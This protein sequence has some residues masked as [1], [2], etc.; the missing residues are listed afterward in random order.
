MKPD[1]LLD[2]ASG[3]LW[4]WPEIFVHHD[5]DKIDEAITWHQDTITMFGRRSPLPRLTAWY[6]DPAAVYSYSGI[7][8]EPLP[9]SPLL[10]QLKED[11]ETCTGGTFNAVLANR[12]VEGTQYM[13]WHADDEAAL[14]KEPWV[15]SVSLGATRRFL[16]KNRRDQRRIELALPH[17]SL[18]LMAGRLQEEWLHALPRTRKPVGLRINLTFR[19]VHPPRP[20]LTRAK[21]DL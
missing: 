19:Y 14:G 20:D 5:V 6:G 21:S 4:Y 8:N 13:S 3:R 1:I 16:L 15:A 7:L 10:R 9:W 11:V 12:Y 17:G 2:D 18:L